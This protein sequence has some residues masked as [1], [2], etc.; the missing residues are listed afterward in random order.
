[1]DAP[2]VVGGGIINCKKGNNLPH[3]HSMYAWWD[4]KDTIKKVNKIDIFVYELVRT[5]VVSFN[6]KA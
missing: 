5:N 2:Y 4:G 3:P 1:M 6:N